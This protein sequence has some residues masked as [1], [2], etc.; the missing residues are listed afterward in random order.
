[1]KK[2]KMS[3]LIDTIQTFFKNFDRFFYW[4]RNALKVYTQPKVFIEGLIA[5]DAKEITKRILEYFCFYESLIL[6]ISA[7]LFN[8]IKFSLFKMPGLIF[9]DVIFALPLILIILIALYTAGIKSPVKKS[10]TYVLVMKIFFGLP[11]QIFFFLFVFFENYVFYI[12]FGGSIQLFA[13]II[14][15][16]PPLFFANR[17]KQALIFFGTTLGLFL[18][19]IFIYIQIGKANPKSENIEQKESYFDPIF[20]EYEK[21]RDNLKL[22]DEVDTKGDIDRADNFSK[23]SEKDENDIDVNKLK[24]DQ[25][26]RNEFMLNRIKN[27]MDIFS[28]EKSC[29]FETNKKRFEIYRE[30]LNELSKYM[31]KAYSAFEIIE[32]K[33]AIFKING[34]LERLNKDLDNF[35]K[36]IYDEKKKTD[37]SKYKTEAELLKVLEEENKISKLAVEHEELNINILEKVNQMWENKIKIQEIL[38]SIMREATKL[39]EARMKFTGEQINYYVFILRIRSLI[40]I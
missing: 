26:Y 8:K 21:Y 29:Y 32:R 1:M 27:E 40:F 23:L 22:I 11:L 4:L 12:L 2:R 33:A 28:E 9:I 38:L 6:I 10:I 34:E 7:T 18:L 15:L 25:K 16:L 13:F 39:D 35:P 17:N 5:K 31:E 19:S 14:L 37:Y 24:E 30:F 36:Y 3:D 20:S